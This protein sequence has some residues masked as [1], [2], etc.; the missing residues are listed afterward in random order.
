MHNES[1]QTSADCLDSDCNVVLIDI[2]GDG[3]PDYVS[4]RIKWIFATIVAAASGI[5]S[6]IL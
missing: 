1:T 3:I 6:V 5:I 4:L 2:D